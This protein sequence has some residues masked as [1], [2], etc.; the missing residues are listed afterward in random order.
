REI[1]V[2]QETKRRPVSFGFLPAAIDAKKESPSTKNKRRPVSFGFLLQRCTPRSSFS[3][4]LCP[5]KNLLRKLNW[6]K[7]E[8]EGYNGVYESHSF[9]RDSSRWMLKAICCSASCS[10]RERE[11]RG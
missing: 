11:A 7:N 6:R 8:V 9:Q 4:A 2:R 3:V 10:A 1:A 5:V